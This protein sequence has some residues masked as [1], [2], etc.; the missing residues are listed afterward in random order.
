MIFFFGLASV[1]ITRSFLPGGALHPV[2]K[3]V[4]PL[5]ATAGGV[6]GPALSYLLLNHFFGSADLRHGWGI[7]TAT[8]IA[9]AWLAAR[10]VFGEGHPAV[11][12]LLL[13][14]VADDFVGVAIIALFYPN[15]AAAVEPLWLALV[16]SGMA[17]A[18][19]LRRAAIKNYW[20]YILL[21]GVPSWIG[22]YRANLHPALALVFIIPFLPHPSR[23]ERGMFEED[24]R[25]LSAMARFEGEWKIIIDFGLFM[26][27]LANAGV[28]FSQIGIA[29][30]LVL[31]ALVLGKTSGIFLFGKAAQKM[32]FHL[33]MGLTDRELFVV[34]LIGGLGFTVALFIAGEAFRDPAIQGGA[35]MG[36][37]MSTLVAIIAIVSGKIL[38]IRKVR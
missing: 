24:P 10:V 5:L 9:F 32:G 31:S 23:E 6:I 34:G 35:K 2:R 11:S 3:S 4:N 33:P 22:L 36:A 25:G 8:D 12:F 17:A 37:M 1:E 20:P 15:P 30:W 28:V 21:G 18:F 16:P 13:L 29:T 14:A 7:P 27:G 19:F 26:F 38:K